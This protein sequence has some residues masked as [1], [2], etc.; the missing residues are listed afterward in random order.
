MDFESQFFIFVLCFYF[1]VPDGE[2]NSKRFSNRE[3]Y[4]LSGTMKTMKAL[5]D[6]FMEKTNY[7]DIP[8]PSF[9]NTVRALKNKR[10]QLIKK[11][12][13]REML[14]NFLDS[15][16]EPPKKKLRRI[17]QLKMRYS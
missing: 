17:H 1:S 8:L 6:F 16:F 2:S 15:E 14:D 12:S 7:D 13:M 9:I 10:T 11:K 5:H 4:E 3:I